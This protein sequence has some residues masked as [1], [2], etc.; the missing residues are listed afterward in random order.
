MNNSVQELDL[1]NNRVGQDAIDHICK[2][3]TSTDD[4]SSLKVLKLENTGLTDRY[5]SY[6]VDALTAN[7]KSAVLSELSFAVNHI[8]DRGVEHIVQ[9]MGSSLDIR[10]LNL[11]WNKIKYKGGLK[12]A[13]A[14]D[15]N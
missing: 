13:E 12:L 3:V 4:I 14:I 10:V 7:A 2:V 5:V 11:H 15:G 8:T 9:I 1:S 6:L